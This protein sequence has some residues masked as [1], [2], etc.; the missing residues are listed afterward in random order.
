LESQTTP[1]SGEKRERL[2][3]ERGAFVAWHASGGGSHSQG[4]KGAHKMGVKKGEAIRGKSRSA[5]VTHQSKKSLGGFV[6]L[7]G[8][9]RLGAMGGESRREKGP[10]G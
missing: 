4:E 1:E 6:H 9:K 5:R 3:A 10:V 2:S 7:K 8:V